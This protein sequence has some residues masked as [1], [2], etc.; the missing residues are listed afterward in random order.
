MVSKTSDTYELT[1]RL[2]LQYCRERGHDDE[3]W[4][5]D[6]CVGVGFQNLRDRECSNKNNGPMAHDS[7]SRACVGCKKPASFVN[8]PRTSRRKRKMRDKTP[9]FGDSQGEETENGVDAP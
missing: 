5:T 3:N 2:F 8:S 4:V 1:L 9:E 7:E 6:S